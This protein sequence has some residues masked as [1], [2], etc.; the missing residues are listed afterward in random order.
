M[1]AV[2]KNERWHERRFIFARMNR[3]Y[4]TKEQALQK[5]KQYCAYQERCHGE[6]KEKLVRFGLHKREIDEVITQLIEEEYLNEERFAIAFAGGKFRIKNWGRIKIKYEL[7]QKSVSDY[8]IKKAL[9]AISE[10]DYLKTFQKIFT[11]KANM[12]KHEKNIFLKKRKIQ[13]H[14]LQKGFELD[15]IKKS[16]DD[17]L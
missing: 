13:D 2:L 16:L 4:I 5:A 8:C 6:I 14:L 17:L 11:A 3:K 7:K 15:M 10:T 1:K 12:L 9:M